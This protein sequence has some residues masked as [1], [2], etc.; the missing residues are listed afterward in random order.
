MFGFSKDEIVRYSRQIVLKEI[1]GIGQKKIQNSSILIVGVGGLGSISSLYLTAAGVGRI[2]LVDDDRVELS[3]LQRQ[4]VYSTDQLGKFKVNA[5]KDTL[6]RLNSSIEVKTYPLKLNSS[7]V[8]E[9]IQQYDFIID[10]TD[11][12]ATKYLVNDAAILENKPLSIGGILRFEGQ[13]MTILPKKSAC[14][15]CVFPDIPDTRFVPTCSQAGVL[16][17][18]VGFGACLQASEALKFILGKRDRLLINKLFI[19]DVLNLDFQIIHVIKNKNCLHCGENSKKLLIADDYIQNL[20]C[21][22]DY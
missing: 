17:S 19:F 6:E 21:N 14:Y 18:V 8:R 3:N 5:A 7:N 13:L 9:I 22:S 11:N 12:F 15:R 1:G 16:G 4:I 20:G 10:G 2:G